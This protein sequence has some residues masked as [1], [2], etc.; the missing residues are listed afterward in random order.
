[1]TSEQYA[2]SLTS[3]AAAPVDTESVVITGAALGLPGVERQCTVFATDQFAYR[4]HKSVVH[5]FGY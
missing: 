2:A 4:G 3:R 1:M 5:R